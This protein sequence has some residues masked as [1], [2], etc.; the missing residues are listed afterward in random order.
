MVEAAVGNTWATHQY[1]HH[2]IER[3]GDMFPRVLCNSPLSAKEVLEI[4]HKLQDFLQ[5]SLPLN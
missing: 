3:N 1:K 4:Y 2:G 5:D